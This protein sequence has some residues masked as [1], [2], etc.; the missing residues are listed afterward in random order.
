MVSALSFSY[1]L[2]W[3]LISASCTTRQSRRKWSTT[4]LVRATTIPTKA[5]A[6]ASREED[7]LTHKMAMED[8]EDMEEVSRRIPTADKEGSRSLQGKDTRFHDRTQSLRPFNYILYHIFR[9]G[10]ASF[11]SQLLF[12]AQIFIWKVFLLNYLS[13]ARSRQERNHF[14]LILD[15]L[16]YPFSSHSVLLSPL[17]DELL[18]FKLIYLAC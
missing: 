8:M 18:H 6:S 5:E 3:P 10:V 9:L 12:G 15:S 14:E 11:A 17:V 7:S 16:L 4:S 13:V 2:S 1:C